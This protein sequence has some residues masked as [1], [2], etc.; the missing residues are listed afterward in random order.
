[1]SEQVENEDGTPMP[2]AE[3]SAGS[4]KFSYFAGPMVRDVT[5]VT[6]IVGGF[7]AALLTVHEGI[8]FFADPS[9]DVGDIVD[10]VF[11]VFD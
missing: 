2:A 1:M 8:N 5:R 3:M 6:V 9:S 10:R 11:G 7:G 4:A